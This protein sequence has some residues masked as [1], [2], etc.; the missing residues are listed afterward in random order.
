MALTTPETIRTLQRKLYAKAKQE[1]AYRLYAL[2]DKISQEDILNHAWRLV[3]ANRGSPGSD[4]IS[5]K[6]IESGIGVDT[7]LRELARDLKAKTYRAQPVRRVMIRKADGSLR[8]LGI[9]TIRDRV[10]QMAVK[11]IIEPIF[12]AD[13]CANSYGFRPKRSAHDAVN[14]IAHTLWAG[15]THVID[16]D[17]SNYFDSIPHAKL[18][19]MVAER[20]VDG[21]ILHLIKLWLKAPV[22]GEDDNGVKRGVGGGNANSKGTPQGGVLSPLLANCYLHQLDRLWQRR[23]LKD[24]LQAHLVRYADDCAPRRRTKG[25]QSFVQPCCTRDEGRPL[26]VAVQAEASNHPWLLPLREVVVSAMGK[27][28]ARPCQV[29]T[30]ESNVSE[31]LRTCRKRRDDV[32]TGGGSLLREESGGHLVTGQMASGMKAARRRSR[33]LWRTWEPVTPMR[34]EKRKW[35]SHKRE[36]TEAG[37]RGGATRSSE[38]GS[39]ME[40]ERRGCLIGLEGREQPAMGGLS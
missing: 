35:R 13:F 6:A 25:R 7:F 23:H 12:E 37:Y 2:Y 15:Y 11:L 21:G 5:F 39:V 22:I 26:E 30:V 18:L 3:R 16:A 28:R 31:P 20:I 9:P 14:D 10:A 24:K 17:L 1:P 4:G 38:E 8:P 19:A 40:L 32:K 29:W 27:G 33:L 34:R 36:S